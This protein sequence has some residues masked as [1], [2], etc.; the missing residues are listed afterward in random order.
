MFSSFRD[1]FFKT[2]AFKLIISY[3]VALLFS[4]LI[5]FGII[6]YKLS[7]YSSEELSKRMLDEVHEF[8][9]LVETQGMKTLY[10]DMKTLI[11]T[12]EYNGTF[13]KVYAKD[14]SLLREFVSPA[15]KNINLDFPKFNELPK[16]GF[17][18]QT[19]RLPGQEYDGMLLHARLGENLL[20]QMGFTVKNENIQLRKIRKLFAVMLFFIFLPLSVV[21]GWMMSHYAT[22]DIRHMTKI[23]IGIREGN[24]SLRMPEI[25]SKY[26]ISS[27]AI[28][29]NS[30]L[31]RLHSLVREYRE[32]TDNIAHDLRSPLTRVIGGI[33]VLLSKQ[34]EQAEYVETLRSTSE[35][36]ASL[37]TMINTL[38]DISSM[39]ANVMAD[40]KTVKVKELFRKVVDIF[41]YSAEEKSIV[42]E[43]E[44]GGALEIFANYHYMTKALSNLVDNAIKYMP[45][46]GGTVKLSAEKTAKD[47]ILKV[48]DSGIGIKSN[49]IPRLFDRFYR[50]DS[51]R[52]SQGNGLG[53]SLVKS[54]VQ[55]HGGHI[56]V[57]SVPEKGTIFSIFLQS[58]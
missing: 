41:Q 49:D 26:E 5:L 15:W 55:A 20:L 17:S 30:M 56:E 6:Y 58:Q 34:R 39:K 12:S 54:V 57:D 45:I 53:L 51:S 44:C 37:H 3:S 48:S 46:E 2:I 32:S 29:F 19:I 25:K 40:C 28:A 47:V 11:E 33:E 35:E 8:K 13:Y 38:L 24:L 22:K 50:A 43:L 4:T 7:E 52:S 16:E 42:L 31:D 27:L 1:K 23:A 36:L 21:V 14:S 18:F 9:V 10:E